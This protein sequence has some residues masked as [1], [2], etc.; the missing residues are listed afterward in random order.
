MQPATVT[1]EHEPVQWFGQYNEYVAGDSIVNHMVQNALLSHVLPRPH[2]EMMAERFEEPREHEDMLDRL[3]RCHIVVLQGRAGTGRYTT[4][5]CTLADLHNK[6]L[7]SGELVRPL[8]LQEIRRGMNDM[9]DISGLTVSPAYG[10]L[11]DI[12]AED[13]SVAPAL[14]RSLF[15]LSASLR[16]AGSYLVVVV[17]E[18]LWQKVGDGAES[19]TLRFR[20]P[21]PEP[22][23]RRHLNNRERA[24]PWLGVEAI[25]NALAGT[26]AAEA[27]RVARMVNDAELMPIENPPAGLDEPQPQQI[28][29]VLAAL[30]DW[31]TELLA[32]YSKPHAPLAHAFLL[33]VAALRKCPADLA[34]RLARGLTKQLEAANLPTGLSAPGVVQLADEADAILSEGNLVAFSRPGY[35]SA[36]LSFFQANRPDLTQELYRWLVELPLAIVEDSA[37]TQRQRTMLAEHAIQRLTEI[38][39]RRRDVALL[40]AIVD[41]WAV[42]DRFLIPAADL[43]AACALD[44]SFGRAVREE[45]LNWVANPNRT[46]A[47]V[48]R[49]LTVATACGRD[50]ATISANITAKRIEHLAG[51]DDPRIDSAVLRAVDKLVRLPEVRPI[52]C[53]A[54]LQQEGSGGVGM[55]AA[56][57]LA[58]GLLAALDD[59]SRVVLLAHATSDDEVSRL[60][61]LWS[62]LLTHEPNI[63]RIAEILAI[64]LAFAGVDTSWK[65]HVLQT[66]AAAVN[67]TNRPGRDRRVAHLMGALYSYGPKYAI[68]EETRDQVAN[69][70]YPQG[71]APASEAYGDVAS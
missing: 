12:R 9:V 13:E 35:G 25:R 11:M 15:D 38:T 6:I 20:G 1:P 64:W 67:R 60:P 53:Q 27:V 8:R 30:R 42:N 66:L 65:A 23:F 32:W 26:N 41:K 57:R 10:Y 39:L 31:R 61:D 4:A 21:R 46:P 55:R 28:R 24:E 71:E 45:T 47:A 69:A 16:R 3:L 43:V 62:V 44:S 36:V 18:K 37:L 19:L 49:A 48:N 7:K 59:D 14:G 58:G 29:A 2:V 54:A 40:R 51:H 63:D 5:V 52:L 50:L 56:V 34:F 17:S 68:N 33:V 70:V 22:V